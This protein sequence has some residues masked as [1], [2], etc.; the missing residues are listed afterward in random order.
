MVNAY[1]T[2]QCAVGTWP[3][4]AL[5]NGAGR[6]NPAFVVGADGVFILEDSSWVKNRT[7]H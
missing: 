5:A 6:H 4:R 7:G 3:N 2:H 1:L